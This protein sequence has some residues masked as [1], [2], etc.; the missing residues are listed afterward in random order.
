MRSREEALRLAA[1][2]VASEMRPPDAIKRGLRGITSLHSPE[3]AGVVERLE[4]VSQTDLDRV[5]RFEPR[6]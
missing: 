3:L 1:E 5:I 2:A 6:Y 4:D